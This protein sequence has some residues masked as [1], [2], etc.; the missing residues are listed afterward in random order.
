MKIRTTTVKICLLNFRSKFIMF[1][2]VTIIL[3]LVQMSTVFFATV[4][5]H[6]S[7]F[8]SSFGLPCVPFVF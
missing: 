7:N 4:A 6:K 2:F 8:K 5:R 3:G 1:Q